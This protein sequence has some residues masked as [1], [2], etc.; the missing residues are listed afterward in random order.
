MAAWIVYEEGRTPE[1]RYMRE[2]DKFECLIQAHEYEQ[3]TYGEKDLDEFQ[4]LSSKISSPE[5]IAWLELLQQERSAHLSKRQRRIPV[6]FVLGT[7][8]LSQLSSMLTRKGDLNV[9]EK[10]CAR[11]SEEYGFQH[12]S[13]EQVLVEKSKEQSYRYA[14][15]LTNCLQDEVDIP[16]DLAV[17]L[18]ESK[19]EEGIKEQGWSLVCGLPKSKDQLLEFERKVSMIPQRKNTANAGRSKKPIIHCF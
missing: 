13:L 7:A 19:I 2:M 12:I 15:F 4:G 5:G 3:R 9:C 17:S 10:Q 16:V 11:V 6:I 8:C 18:L 14:G 1:A